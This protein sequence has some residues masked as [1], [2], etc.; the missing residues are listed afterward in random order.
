MVNCSALAVD[1]IPACFNAVDSSSL[2]FPNPVF[3]EFK[4]VFLR[5]PNAA[6]PI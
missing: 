4:T 2:D 1:A 5:C 3:K 6:L